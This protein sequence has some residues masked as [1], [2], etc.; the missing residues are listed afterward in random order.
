MLQSGHVRKHQLQTPATAA[1]TV[2]V[3]III[4]WKIIG[5]MPNLSIRN[6]KVIKWNADYSITNRPNCAVM[7]DITFLSGSQRK[8]GNYRKDKR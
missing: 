5:R 3:Q 2:F 7:G 8:S 4:V 6:S 1:F